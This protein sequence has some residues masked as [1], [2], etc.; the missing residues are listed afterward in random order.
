MKLLAVLLI[1]SIAAYCAPAEEEE[2]APE[3]TALACYR[4]AGD[5]F[6]IE[7]ITTYSE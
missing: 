2:P 6:C 5:L 1:L 3:P 4:T 7:K